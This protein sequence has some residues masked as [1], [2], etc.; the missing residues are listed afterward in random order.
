MTAFPGQSPSHRKRPGGNSRSSEPRSSYPKRNPGVPGTQSEDCSYRHLL[1]AEYAF[2]GL[3]R[4]Q[5]IELGVTGE[6]VDERH[7]GAA[8]PDEAAAS[9]RIG[10]I[11]HLLVG[12][13]EEL[14]QLCPVGRRLV[15][16]DDK[17]RV[18][19]HGAGLDGIQKVLHVLGDSS[20]VGPTLSKLPPCG[21]KENAALL[22]LKHHME[23]VDEHMGALAPF[24]VEGDAVEDRIGDDQGTGRL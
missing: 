11:A 3:G 2:T 19:E 8:I 9:V 6:S 13:I 17:L 4:H 21:I 1:A 7:Q 15:Q 5:G 24:P 16:H 10:D 22:I 14:R 18:R 23:L 20:R 12:D